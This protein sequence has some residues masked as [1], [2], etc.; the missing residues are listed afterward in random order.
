[1]TF[2]WDTII[3]HF[4]HDGRSI[5]RKSATR[6]QLL[7][8]RWSDASP[9]LRELLHEAIEGQASLDRFFRRFGAF[10]EAL[11]ASPGETL[12]IATV[13]KLACLSRRDAI[14]G[15]GATVEVGE[16]G[17]SIVPMTLQNV[18][19]ELLDNSITFASP[20]RPLHISIGAEPQIDHVR[21][22]YEDNASGWDSSLA[23]KLFLPL[24]RLDSRGGFGLGL[25]I[26]TALVEGAGGAI[27]ATTSP[28]GSKFTI[29]LPPRG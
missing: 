6:N 15:A 16:L 4:V 25:A 2:D 27:T 1:M 11:N 5:L 3:P 8:R 18:L 17:E 14:Q 13:I 21:I 10:H 7:D 20:D 12:P 28:A 26:A 19:E 9:E 23:R 22:T 29:D 24:E